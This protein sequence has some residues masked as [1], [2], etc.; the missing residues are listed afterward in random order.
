ML[1]D[2]KSLRSANSLACVTGDSLNLAVTDGSHIVAIRFRSSDVEDPPSL[3]YF[4]LGQR[5]DGNG[6]ANPVHWAA[7]MTSLEAGQ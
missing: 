3:Y 4:Q 2:L 1:H 7:N 5:W 6:M